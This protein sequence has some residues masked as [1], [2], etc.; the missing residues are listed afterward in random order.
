VIPSRC[1]AHMCVVAV[2]IPAI[3]VV[4]VTA[5]LQT[6]LVTGY[7]HCS[8]AG[9]L[10]RDRVG[11]VVACQV[12]GIASG[13][14]LHRGVGWEW[15]SADGQFSYPLVEGRRPGMYLWPWSP[16]NG[17]GQALGCHEFAVKMLPVAG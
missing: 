15:V 1:S 8:S 11:I 6:C 4:P 13:E 5:D 9:T 12:A 14:T 7:G 17:V 2:R 10:A 16:D 3:P